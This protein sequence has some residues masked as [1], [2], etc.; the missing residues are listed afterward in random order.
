MIVLKIAMIFL[1]IAVILLCMEYLLL[2]NKVKS[3]D[4]KMNIFGDTD[5]FASRF[6]EV[7]RRL[8]IV[9]KAIDIDRINDEKEY[10]RLKEKLGK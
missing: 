4:I 9:E 6:E 8:N 10:E 1:A 3:H 5:V 2:L 7:V